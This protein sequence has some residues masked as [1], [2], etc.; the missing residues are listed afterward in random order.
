MLHTLRLYLFTT[1]FLLDINLILHNFIYFRTLTNLLLLS[2]FLFHF[3]S[4]SQ[5]HKKAVPAAPKP[6]DRSLLT[7]AQK[8]EAD[9]KAM[10]EKAA[11]KAAEASGA[12][13]K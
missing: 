8:K 7:P 6:G 11:K 13:S 1:F 3:S 4:Q 9:A 5:G 2:F 12:A 10:A